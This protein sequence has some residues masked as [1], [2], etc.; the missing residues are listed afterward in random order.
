MDCDLPVNKNEIINFVGNW[1]ELT[2]NILSEVSVLV[3]VSVD[4]VVPFSS[5]DTMTNN[6]HEEKCLIGDA[7][8]F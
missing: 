1:E 3:W 5:C 7:L 8:Q 2:E 4:V 6:S